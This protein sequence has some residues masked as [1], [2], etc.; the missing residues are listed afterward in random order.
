MMTA[1]A[2]NANGKIGGT[3]CCKRDSYLAIA[4]AVKFVKLNL[5]IE[6][7]LGEINCI[8]SKLN[9]QCIGERCPFK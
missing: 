1:Q 4:E 9:N 2:L 7:E 6:M 5:G 8:H 3:R